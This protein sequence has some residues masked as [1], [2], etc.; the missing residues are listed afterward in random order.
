MTQRSILPRIALLA[1]LALVAFQPGAAQAQSTF[2]SVP[3]TSD[4]T[5]TYTP[6]PPPVIT[7]QPETPRVVG[8]PTRNM[9]M[10]DFK[11]PVNPVAAQVN[12]TQPRRAALNRLENRLTTEPASALGNTVAK[13]PNSPPPA[14]LLLES[15]Q[16]IL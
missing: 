16:P 2:P 15:A 1:G 13:S 14:R 7:R 4:F 9:P 3:P 12:P 5:P 11:V 8:T 10:P 6:P